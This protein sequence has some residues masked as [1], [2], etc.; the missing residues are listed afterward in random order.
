MANVPD[1]FV[2]RQ[3][4]DFVQRERQLDDAEIRSEVSAVDGTSADERV[5]NLTGQ[6]I[7]FAA[8]EA[9]DVGW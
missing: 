7:D 6:N 9:F 5:S 1:E 4:E 2:G 3:I 8:F